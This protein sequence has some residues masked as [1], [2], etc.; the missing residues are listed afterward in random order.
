VST[1]SRRYAPVVRAVR[2]V[3]KTVLVMIGLLVL[4]AMFDLAF[5]LVQATL[6]RWFKECPDRAAGRP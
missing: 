1:V 4:A 3:R 5:G 6:P 2:A